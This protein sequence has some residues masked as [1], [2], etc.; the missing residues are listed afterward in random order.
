MLFASCSMC[1]KQI[2]SYRPAE[3]H[4][5]SVGENEDGCSNSCGPSGETLPVLL[6]QYR[7]EIVEQRPSKLSFELLLIK[8]ARIATKLGLANR[9]RGVLFPVPYIF[10]FFTVLASGPILIS[11]RPHNSFQWAPGMC[12]RAL[13]L[14]TVGPKS[15]PQHVFIMWCLVKPKAI[16]VTGREGL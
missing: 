13:K 12:S 10:I 2:A 7:P 11:R 8:Q 16:P 15:T 1:F 9:G 3:R 14:T 5:T 4:G 6:I